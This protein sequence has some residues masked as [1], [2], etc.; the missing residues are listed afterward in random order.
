MVQVS[1][2]LGPGNFPV[3]TY[4]RSFDVGSVKVRQ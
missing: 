4:P 3:N 2:G 1:A